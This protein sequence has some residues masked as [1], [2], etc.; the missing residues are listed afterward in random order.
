MVRVT[1]DRGRKTEDFGTAEED[2]MQASGRRGQM[3]ESTGK[4]RV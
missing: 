4:S 1:M 2:L 3:V